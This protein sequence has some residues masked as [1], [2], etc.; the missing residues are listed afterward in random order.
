MIKRIQEKEKLGRT[1]NEEQESNSALSGYN[2]GADLDM[3]VFTYFDYLK[4]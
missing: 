2:V 1:L 3:S 4:F